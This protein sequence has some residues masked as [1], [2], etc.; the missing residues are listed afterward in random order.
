MKKILDY[1]MA[2]CIH[3]NLLL[4]C[5][6]PDEWINNDNT[7]DVNNPDCAC[8]DDNDKLNL[9]VPEGAVGDHRRQQLLHYIL[10]HHHL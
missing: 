7:T 9:A 10:E 1:V 5:L 8:L 2:A 6:I 3:H 4:E